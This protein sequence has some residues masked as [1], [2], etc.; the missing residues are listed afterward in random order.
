MNCLRVLSALI[1]WY[2]SPEWWLCILGFPTLICIGWQAIATTRAARATEASVEA[3]KDT[4]KRQLRAYIAVTIDSASYQDREKNIK[5]QGIPRLTNTGQTP[6]HKLLL[7]NHASVLPWPL[8]LSYVLPDFGDDIG[9]SVMGVGQQAT[10]NILVESFYDD[11]EVAG[12]MDGSSGKA[13]Y[14]WGLITYEDAFGDSH[15]TQFCQRLLFFPSTTN[16][17]QYTVAGQYTPGR[18]KAT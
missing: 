8:P 10:M 17:G 18:N 15:E 11:R 7:K 9:E 3:G 16:P 6:A 5:F 1:V 4:A 12:I 14:C 2:T 13:L